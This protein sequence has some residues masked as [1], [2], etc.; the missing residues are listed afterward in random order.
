MFNFLVEIKRALGASAGSVI[1]MAALIEYPP[2]L[3]EE[4]LKNI[5]RRARKYNFGGFHRDFDVS[6]ILRVR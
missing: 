2:P 3:M 5:V 4:K 1:A 6:N